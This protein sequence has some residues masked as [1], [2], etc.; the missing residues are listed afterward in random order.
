[1]LVLV[2]GCERAGGELTS[3]IKAAVRVAS[4]PHQ[5]LARP[6]SSRSVVGVQL[7]FT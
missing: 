1:M 3:R 7:A 2:L 6:V 4:E 5:R